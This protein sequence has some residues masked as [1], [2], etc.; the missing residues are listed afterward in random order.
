MPKRKFISGSKIKINSFLF[1]GSSE[2]QLEVP[3]Q[4]RVS[5]KKTYNKKKR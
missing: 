3:V 1:E 2:E 4:Q 5:K